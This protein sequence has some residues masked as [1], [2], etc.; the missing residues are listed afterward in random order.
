MV[1]SDEVNAKGKDISQNLIVLT[2]SLG[3]GASIIFE[4]L[5]PAVGDSSSLI[6]LKVDF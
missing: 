5:D 4:H 2:N 3:S 6:G 1:N